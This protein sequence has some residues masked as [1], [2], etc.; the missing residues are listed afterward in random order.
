MYKGHMTN[1]ILGTN[2]AAYGTCI[3]KYNY[4]TF[5]K[6]GTLF[7]RSFLRSEHVA[8]DIDVAVMQE[9]RATLMGAASTFF[10]A[11]RK[12]WMGNCRVRIP[13]TQVTKGDT[14]M[15]PADG[16][17]ARPIAD[18]VRDENLQLSGRTV[19]ALI[20]R[21]RVLCTAVAQNPQGRAAAAREALWP[22][23]NP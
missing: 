21:D 4:M 13:T 9:P 6:Q 5:Q 23:T 19:C 14:I 1:S 22:G 2:W 7:F 20:D 18:V 10:G 17:Y 3:G 15:M 16:S 8:P 12:A 11:S